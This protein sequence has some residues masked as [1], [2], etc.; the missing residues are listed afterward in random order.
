MK[1]PIIYRADY[2][3]HSGNDSRVYVRVYTTI[4][5]DGSGRE[6]FYAYHPARLGCGKNASTPDAAVLRLVNDHGCV[7][8]CKRHAAHAGRPEV[9]HQPRLSGRTAEG[10]A[11]HRARFSPVARAVCGR[12]RRSRDAI[13]GF[14]DWEWHGTAEQLREVMHTPATPAS[15]AFISTAASTSPKPC[16]TST[17]AHMSHG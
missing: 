6:V 1:N 8:S 14:G 16:A 3:N 9:R 11:H 13:V 10:E 7:T 4:A 15:P 17:M 12:H 5:E 2:V